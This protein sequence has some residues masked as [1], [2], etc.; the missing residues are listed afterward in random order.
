MQSM[1]HYITFHLLRCQSN[2]TPTACSETRN[3]KARAR[4][5]RGLSAGQGAARALGRGRRSALG[6]ACMR[7][8]PAQRH[9]VFVGQWGAWGAGVRRGASGCIGVHRGWAGRWQ[10]SLQRPGR[11]MQR[12]QAF[13]PPRVLGRLSPQRMSR[14]WRSGRF[15]WP[16]GCAVRWRSAWLPRRS[17]V[18]A[19]ARRRRT[20]PPPSGRRADPPRQL[21]P[22]GRSWTPR[23]IRFPSCPGGGPTRSAHRRCGQW[24][25][26]SRG[27]RYAPRRHACTE[28]RVVAGNLLGLQHVAPD[29]IGKRQTCRKTRPEARAARQIDDRAYLNLQYF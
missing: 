7:A 24:C 4:G 26:S 22:R 29:S 13:L 3:E 27:R 21:R 23:L 9:A 15:P 19:W 17:G 28:R 1:H 10:A 11:R 5:K 6:R 8:R 2:S 18:R 20:P 16:P 14:G 25:G 12:A